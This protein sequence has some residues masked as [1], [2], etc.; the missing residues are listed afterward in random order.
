MNNI[1]D[2]RLE[3]AEQIASLLVQLGYDNPVSLYKSHLDKLRDRD[4]YRLLVYELDGRV[5][6]LLTVH[7]YTQ[8]I[9]VGEIANLGVFVVDENVRSK[10]VGRS[11]EEYATQ[12][13]KER[14]C[15]LVELFSLKERI[16]AHRFYIRQGFTER[17]KFFE[18]EL[19]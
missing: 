5:V 18:K 9:F 7:F 1:R 19:K 2:A 13:A 8:L 10:G 12:M 14:G 4:D 15:C 17:E 11:M 6:G 3:D 16:D